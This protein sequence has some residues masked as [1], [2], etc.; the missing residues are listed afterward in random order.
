MQ[1]ALSFWIQHS[2]AVLFTV[3]FLD[4]L[5]V[6]LPAFPL[7][8]G[9]GVLARK[10]DASLPVAIAIAVAAAF[11]AY[12]FWYEAGRRGGKR[13]LDLVCRVA[14]EPD[15]CI[16][17]TENVFVRHGLKSLIVAPFIFGLG[18][19]AR[20]LAGMLRIPF[21]QFTL[22]SVAGAAL[23]AGTFILLGYAFGEPLIALV[24]DAARLGGA[25]IAIVGAAAV[26]YIGW[27]VVQR[28]LFARRLRTARILPEELKEKLD[29]GG[30][31]VILD[32][33]HALDVQADPRKIPGAMQI[34]PDQLEQ[35]QIEIPRG[36]EVI[37]YCT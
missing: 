32:L 29:S 18:T 24:Q 13:I 10:G 28:Q 19:V 35:R 15:T 17:R 9:V 16:R 25:F 6:P 11:V 21:L 26:G 27:K 20:P 14:L 34:S 5:G 1:N 4:Q 12:C 23:W 31:I 33:R 3:V 36:Q 30:A 22:F 37:L 8:I 7:L 2:Y